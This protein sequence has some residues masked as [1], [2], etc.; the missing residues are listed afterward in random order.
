MTLL[1]SILGKVRSKN[2]LKE[3]Q[4]VQDNF[5]PSQVAALVESLRSEFRV[6][7]E[8]IVPVRI[9]I[10]EMKEKITVIGDRFTHV[11]TDVRSIKDAFRIAFPDLT[12]RVSKLETKVFG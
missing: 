2:S 8:V 4:M 7:A 5:T 12:Q 1:S 9:D 11:E 6:L 3:A 10:T